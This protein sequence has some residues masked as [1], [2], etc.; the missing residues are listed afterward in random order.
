[1]PQLTKVTAR[2]SPGVGAVPHEQDRGLSQTA[3]VVQLAEVTSHQVPE[4]AL[5][6]DLHAELL[7]ISEEGRE[8][9]EGRIASSDK[10]NASHKVTVKKL[11]NAGDLEDDVGVVDLDA[12]RFGANHAASG[13]EIVEGVLLLVGT[14]GPFRL[15]S[16]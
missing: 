10:T 5:D 7:D 12:I 14:T 9:S 4:F 16:V 11:I 13:A 3:T 8:G 6:A 2:L 1:M 15:A